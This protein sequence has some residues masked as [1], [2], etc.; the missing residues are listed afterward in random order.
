VA[1]PQVFS[2][3]ED[4]AL[5]P[6][7]RRCKVTATGVLSARDLFTRLL[8]PTGLAIGYSGGKYGIFD[9]WAMPTP[10]DAALT[11]TT[12]LYGGETGKPKTATP[13]QNVRKWSTIDRLDN[14]GRIDPQT[15]KYKDEVE[16]AATYPGCVYRPQQIRQQIL[17]DYL[18][19][20][21]VP[22][23]GNDW[24]GELAV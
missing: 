13:M 23:I 24:L 8:A 16:R 18:I 15:R 11:I 19:H 10:D 4:T 20:P 1:D 21:S 7:L 9:A 22:I 3:V 6:H 2:A 12:E 17:G 14:N 5:G